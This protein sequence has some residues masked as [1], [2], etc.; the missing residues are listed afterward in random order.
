MIDYLFAAGP[1]LIA[2]I[3]YFVRLEIRLTKICRDLGWIKR[4]MRI[5]R[6]GSENN[7]P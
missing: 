1:V 4:E 3:I 7:F 6:P 2:L 5:C